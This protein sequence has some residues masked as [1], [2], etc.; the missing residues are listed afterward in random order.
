[1]SATITPSLST[2]LA[3]LD[4]SRLRQA[5][6]AHRELANAQLVYTPDG[7]GHIRTGGGSDL[8]CGRANWPST[9]TT[10][11][12]WSFMSERGLQTLPRL[13]CERCAEHLLELRET[14]E[15]ESE[16]LRVS[17]VRARAIANALTILQDSAR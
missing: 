6:S 11:E 10:P 9:P 15:D 12:R 17:I 3:D 1:M 8:V 4:S 16:E 13:G 2:Q 14:A 5:F 7:I